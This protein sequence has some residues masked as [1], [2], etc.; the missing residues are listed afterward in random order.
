MSNNS[1]LTKEEL[2]KRL[3]AVESKLGYKWVGGAWH[4]FGMGSEGN[5]Q[6]PTREGEPAGNQIIKL[7][8]H[9]PTGCWIGGGGDGGQIRC[10]D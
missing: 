1:E 5:G 6:F 9:E 7:T 4:F 8:F 10:K 3:D 2:V